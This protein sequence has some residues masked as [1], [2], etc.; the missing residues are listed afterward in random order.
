MP[1]FS[2]ITGNS[3]IMF[4][5][6]V[7]FDGTKRGGMVTTD[8]QLLIGSTAAPNIKTGT[9]TSLDG[10]L[11]IN[12]GPGTIDLAAG[13]IFGNKFV[14]NT[15]TASF[16]S[17]I[18]NIKGT[19]TNGIQTAASG[20]TV[21]A[22][23]Q[24][25]YADGD[26]DFQSTVSGQTR[27]LTVENTSNTASSQATL[28][29]KV[30]GSSAGNTW[31][32]YTSGS[33]QSYAMGILNSTS[34]PQL[35]ITQSASGSADPSTAT[36]LQQ[37][38]TTNT[39]VVFPIPL[40]V[41][42]SAAGFAGVACNLNI[43][44]PNT[45]AASDSSLSLQVSP[46]TG[47]NAYINYTGPANNWAH[48]VDKTGDSSAWKLTTAISGTFPYSTVAIKST[49]AGNIT[50]P[51]TAAFLANGGGT[52]NAVTGDGT[53]YTIQFTNAV[54]DQNSN[55]NTSTGIFTAPV[56]GKYRFSASVI[57]TS[58]G[59]AHTSGQM[60]LVATGGSYLL[61]LVN[62]FTVANASGQLSLTASTAV[63]MTAGDTAKMVVTISGSTK[64]INIQG[65][66]GFN[67]VFSG[68]LIA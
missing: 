25:P 3:S 37:F 2:T 40:G 23:M 1:G 7:S 62:P 49:T 5:D 63:L 15:G 33:A 47:G 27:T 45:T 30:A 38:D 28:L 26:F 4:A 48:G 17:F 31:T 21:I 59:A 19:S 44:N 29:L 67:C 60:Y 12:L 46:A 20:N 24:S 57:F 56:T 22:R 68:E 11:T 41:L 39:R 42:G 36:V 52:Q 51:T 55:Y 35:R 6:N 10:S 61:W 66:P 54:Y 64:T 8:G 18:L 16:S 13:P 65:N 50:F 32:Q 53:A 58:I 34:P 9:I 43:L 14:G